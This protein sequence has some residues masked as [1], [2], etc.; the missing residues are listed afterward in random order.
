MRAAKDVH[1]Q[2]KAEEAEQA[3]QARCVEPAARWAVISETVHSERRRD[4]SFR[5]LWPVLGP[6]YPAAGTLSG[7][8]V[9][10]HRHYYHLDDGAAALR[11]AYKLTARPAFL[12]ITQ[13][14]FN[15]PERPH[16]H[17]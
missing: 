17:R 7:R 1:S 8:T 3:T 11:S 12:S 2:M 14:D 16:T 4:S 15:Q 10:N 13:S 9:R 6:P 5:H